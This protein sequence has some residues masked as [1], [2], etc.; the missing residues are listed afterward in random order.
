MKFQDPQEYRDWPNKVVTLL[1]MSGVGKTRLSNKLPRDSWFHYSVDYRIGTRYME[2]PIVDNIKAHAMRDPFLRCLLMSDSIFIGSNI[3]VDNLDPLSTFLGKIGDPGKHGLSREEFVRR[4]KLHRDAE[5]ASMH[6]MNPFVRKG[7]EI[8]G[9]PNF[10]C[11]ASGS[12]SEV[13]DFGSG[14]DPVV[15]VV[16]DNSLLLYIRASEEDEVALKARAKA[17]PKPLYY[18]QD[19]LAKALQEFLELRNL[20]K[21]EQMNPDDFVTWVFP[22]LVEHRRPRYNMLGETYGYVIESHE[23]AGVRD[24]DDFTDLVCL[25]ISRQTPGKKKS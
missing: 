8:Y 22:K 6:D 11:D 24:E 19:F 7:K 15:K 25:A 3:T 14:K 2:E 21:A 20:T 5:V 17:Q 12:L 1:G 10:V 18:R 23:V 16:T 13:V 9:Y 4:Q